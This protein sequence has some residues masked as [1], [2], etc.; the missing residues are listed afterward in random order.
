M[1]FLHILMKKRRISHRFLVSMPAFNEISC[2]EGKQLGIVVPDYALEA[3]PVF[4]VKKS[5]ANQYNKDIITD[6][7]TAYD[8]CKEDFKKQDEPIQ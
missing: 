6:Y 5:I 4:I 8:L 3:I 2:L 1:I 7:E